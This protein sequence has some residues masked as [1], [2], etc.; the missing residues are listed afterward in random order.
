M[1]F[2]DIFTLF[3][4]SPH[5]FDFPQSLGLTWWSPYPLPTW[6]VETRERG[7][8][9]WIREGTVKSRHGYISANCRGRAFGIWEAADSL[10]VTSHK[11]S[12]ML[13]YGSHCTLCNGTTLPVPVPSTCAVFAHRAEALGCLLQ[14]W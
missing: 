7:V 5:C 4:F 3:S 6:K 1:D 12:S 10:Q 9:C 14:P 13:P 2:G 8:T 11:S